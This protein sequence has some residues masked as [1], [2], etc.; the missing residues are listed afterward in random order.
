MKL[1]TGT[2]SIGCKAVPQLP[3]DER[4]LTMDFPSGTRKITTLKNEPITRPVINNITAMKISILTPIVHFYSNC[5]H[6]ILE[7]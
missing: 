3:Q 5:S 2:K 7:I 6:H 1:N 4:G